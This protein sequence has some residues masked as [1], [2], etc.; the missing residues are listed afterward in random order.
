MANAGV[1]FCR[2]AGLHWIITRAE[3]LPG[4]AQG[5]LTL[6][7]PRSTSYSRKETFTPVTFYG[8]LMPGIRLYSRVSFMVDRA[9]L[10][11]ITRED[12]IY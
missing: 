7:T 3:Q 6:T 12:P 1:G 4:S 9:K 2:F 10:P 11:T 5:A 8:F